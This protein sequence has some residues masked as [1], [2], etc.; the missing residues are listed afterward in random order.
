MKKVLFVLLLA[1]SALNGYCQDVVYHTVAKAPRNMQ[2][3]E[4]GKATPTDVRIVRH[5]NSSIEIGA[6]KYNVVSVD[7]KV[8]TDSVVSVQYTTCNAS[9]EEYVIK[10]ESD[11]TAAVALM[12]DF[13]VVFATA[14]P[15]D[16]MYYFGKPEE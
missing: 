14:H 5:G 10:F 7:K 8:N 12:R 3:E 1:V 11:R 4:Y 6:E 15:F 2:T 13:I 9:G 16:W